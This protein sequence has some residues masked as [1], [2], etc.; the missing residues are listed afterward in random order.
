METYMRKL[1]TFLIAAIFSISVSA[2]SFGSMML[3]GVSGGSASTPFSITHVSDNSNAAGT[4]SVP[5]SR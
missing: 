4:S 3:L 1:L 2:S 5:A